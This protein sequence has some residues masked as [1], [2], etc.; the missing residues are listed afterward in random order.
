MATMD[1]PVYLRIGDTEEVHLGTVEADPGEHGTDVRLLVA[2]LLQR[3]AGI[4]RD[5]PARA[6]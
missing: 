6:R 3:A 1:I 5:T 4:I 2:E